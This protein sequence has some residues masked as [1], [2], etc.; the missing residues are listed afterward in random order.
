METLIYGL[1]SHAPLEL[2]YTLSKHENDKISPFKGI[3]S[4]TY[5]DSTGGNEQCLVNKHCTKHDRPRLN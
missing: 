5:K 3:K 1:L 2:C 4:A